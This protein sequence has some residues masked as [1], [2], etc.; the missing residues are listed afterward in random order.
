[1]A[2][3]D[4]PEV[5][6]QRYG[7]HA[8]AVEMLPVPYGYP[9]VE[10]LTPQGAVYAFDRG[11]PPSP[12]GRL[13]VLFAAAVESFRYRRLP[14]G[15]QSYEGG[16]ALLA[17]RVVRRLSDDAFL[18]DAGIPLV[19]NSQDPLEVGATLEVITAPPLMIFREEV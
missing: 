17:G 16:R 1:V 9:L 2:F 18:F 13:N 7:E 11:A 5:F 4:S 6:W 12:I 14:A 19:I 8:V 15:L 10:T 3:E